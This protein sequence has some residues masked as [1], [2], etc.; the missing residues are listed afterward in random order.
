MPLA[1]ESS[2]AEVCRPSGTRVCLR[3]YPGLTPW[4]N[5]FRPSGAG[6]WVGV[7]PLAPD[8]L[9]PLTYDGHRAGF[10]PPQCQ[11]RE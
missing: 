10:D 6:A 11:G 7:L 5:I 8:M 9:S 2:S 4:A 3:A 1:V